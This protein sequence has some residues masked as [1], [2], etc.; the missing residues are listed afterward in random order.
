MIRLKIKVS[1]EDKTYTQD[2]LLEDDFVIAKT[3]TILQQMVQKACDESII[4]MIDDV[5]VRAS[6]DW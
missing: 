3:N 6:F 5:I 4:E 1:G 2:F